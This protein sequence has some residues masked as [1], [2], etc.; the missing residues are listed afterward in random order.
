LDLLRVNLGKK[1]EESHTKLELRQQ[2]D[3]SIAAGHAVTAATLLRQ[4]WS[5]EKTSATASFVVQ[6]F[7]QI[8]GPLSLQ[9][10]RLAILRSFTVEPMVP[11]L[12]AA[13]FCAGLDLSV[14]VSDFNAY[15]QAIVDSGS[16]LYSFD[17]Q[18]VILAVQARDVAPELWNH[19]GA[20]TSESTQAAADRV[21]ADFRNWIR[22][23]RKNSAAHLIVHNLEQPAWPSRGVLDAQIADGPR[24]AIESVNR[25]LTAE[26]A[27]NSSVYVLDY[28]GL[29]ARHGRE[30][31]HDERKWLTVRLPITAECLPH[32]AM[33]WMRYLHPLSGK[34][35]KALVVDL[36][37]TLWGGVIGED[38]MAGIRLGTEYPGAAFQ[39]LQ[40][41]LLDLYQRGI[42][43]AVCSKNN[44]YDAQEALEKHPGMVLSPSHFAA[45]RIN[46]Q[47]KAQN[48][49]EI[50]KELNIGVDSLA[51]F[52]D[53]PIER[54]QVRSLL[55][56]VHVI[57]LPNDPMQYART[58]RDCPW[59]ERLLLSQEDFERGKMYQAQRER[60]ELE[61][62]LTSRE[63]F[64]RSLQQEA[65]IA[66]LLPETLARVAQ[67]TNKTNQFNLTTRRYSEQQI[68]E[69]SSK[70]GWEVFSIKLRDRFGDNGLVGVAI[71]HTEN[72]VCEIDAFLLSCRVIGRTV[73]TALLWFLSERASEHGCQTLQGCFL[74]TKK[75]APALDFYPN[76]GFTPA[77]QNGDGTLW[78]LELSPNPLR[79][80]DWVQVNIATGEKLL[81]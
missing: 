26:V 8:L 48:L 30:R 68:K 11:M 79:C 46:W 53:N 39:D 36:D 1:R 50:A 59:F 49:R 74:P 57:D 9:P 14:Q 6:R 58:V 56:E 61:Q 20:L 12:R 44:L 75:N 55:P 35:V 62:T 29:V 34:T 54:Q 63:D 45:L 70:P 72:K 17:P 60:D 64:Y 31:W 42:L 41:A 38:G 47:D 40:R 73:E 33:E 23:F 71:T 67:L 43:L 5:T 7:E 51:F 21:S 78:T 28:D 27:R 19:P 4:L 24:S 3:E 16:S 66:P 76:H 2:I 80:P 18:V 77:P 65:E 10:Y 32:M 81:R 37:N 22:N 69:L 25:E 52:D 15:V 13:A